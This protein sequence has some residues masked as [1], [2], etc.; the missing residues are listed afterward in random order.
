MV[1]VTLKSDRS[2]KWG[3]AACNPVFFKFAVK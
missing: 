3:R 1:T 2:F